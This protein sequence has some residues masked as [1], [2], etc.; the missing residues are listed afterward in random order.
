MSVD[1]NGELARK[2]LNE[3]A[4]FFFWKPIP[5]RH[6]IN[7][8]QHVFKKKRSLTTETEESEGISFCQTSTCAPAN[9]QHLPIDGKG[10]SKI[11]ESEF[12]DFEQNCVRESQRVSIERWQS[13]ENE[14][15]GEFTRKTNSNDSSKKLICVEEKRR[16]DK[17]NRKTEKNSRPRLR[18]TP[19]LHH[20]FMEALSA[21][22]EKSNFFSLNLYTYF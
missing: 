17:E 11:F 19:D 14:K 1:P 8:W 6:I 21:L 22:R 7:V 3:G 4:C 20:K 18:W 2:A 16:K 10:K 13:L 5:T 9:I 12:V 15:Q